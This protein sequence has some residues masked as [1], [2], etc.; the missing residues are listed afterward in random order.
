MM[1]CL[2]SLCLKDLLVK[3]KGPPHHHSSAHI[4]HV[5]RAGSCT[6]FFQEGSENYKWPVTVMSHLLFV[7]VCE[8]FPL[9]YQAYLRGRTMRLTM[10]PESPFNDSYSYRIQAE[11]KKQ[12]Y[13]I[14]ISEVLLRMHS[15][16]DPVK[17]DC[18]I[19]VK[20]WLAVWGQQSLWLCFQFLMWEWPLA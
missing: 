14:L 16:G 20:S 5:W 12:G 9:V 19:C 10:V 3:G 1:A 4:A 17:E 7:C 13:T 8:C 2:A 11:T 15:G 6:S 18:E